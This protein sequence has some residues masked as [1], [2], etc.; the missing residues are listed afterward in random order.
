M[1]AIKTRKLGK[2][3]GAGQS[4]IKG[5]HEAYMVLDYESFKRSDTIIERNELQIDRK[6]LTSTVGVPPL[7]T[8]VS[9]L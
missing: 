2:E 4:I 6:N 8:I 3:C 5:R 1:D 7:L 9:F